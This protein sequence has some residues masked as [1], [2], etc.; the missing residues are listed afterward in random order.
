MDTKDELT[1][2]GLI[3]CALDND[4]KALNKLHEKFK[5]LLLKYA[6]FL[7][8]N[9]EEI[10]S[11]FDLL[12]I[13]I[14]KANLIDDIKILS[15]IKTSFKNLQRVEQKQFVFN[16]ENQEANLNSNVIF[17]DLI[18]DLDEKEQEFLM[19]RFIEGY[20]F[21]DIGKKYDVT[22]QAVQQRFKYILKK[23]KKLI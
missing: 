22:R 20:T 10:I 8:M 16:Y 14:D 23:L 2:S 17:F 4:Y 7:G 9:I 3:K 11:E 19:L 12:I 1:I 21:S 6:S 15:Y 18:K 5:P 13:K